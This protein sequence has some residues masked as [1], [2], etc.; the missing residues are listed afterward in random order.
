MLVKIVRVIYTRDGCRT[1][2]LR[3]DFILF[4]FILLYRNDLVNP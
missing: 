2:I 3:T 4:G 1:P